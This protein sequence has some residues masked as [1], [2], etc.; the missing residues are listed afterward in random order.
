[1]LRIGFHQCVDSVAQGIGLERF[2]SDCRQ[3]EAVPSFAVL[4]R[5]GAI[6]TN[7][8]RVR[9]APGVWYSTT[10]AALQVRRAGFDTANTL[11]QHPLVDGV[12]LRCA[13]VPRIGRHLDEPLLDE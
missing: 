8:P 2:T 11:F 10:G 12:G 7:R 6:S 4:T 13:S 3:R 9:D 5:F 1:M